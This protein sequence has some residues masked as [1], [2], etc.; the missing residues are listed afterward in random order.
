M[1]ILATTSAMMIPGIMSAQ[2][3]AQASSDISQTLDDARSYAIANHTYVFVGFEEV[4]AANSPN[5]AGQA[6]ATAS[7]G[8]RIAVA[9]VASKDGTNSYTSAAPYF[10]SVNLTPISK[11]KFFSGV[12]LADFSA[13]SAAGGAM[14]SRIAV[15]AVCS[16]LILPGSLAT[17][18]SVSGLLHRRKESVCMV[19]P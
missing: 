2:T 16:A 6:Q 9:I 8:G 11:V 12:H 1:V 4:S 5:S 15:A 17:Q 13:L 10:N 14:S 19:K 18:P 7:A 3:V